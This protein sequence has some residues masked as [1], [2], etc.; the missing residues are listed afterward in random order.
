M[1]SRTGICVPGIRGGSSERLDA[2]SDSILGGDAPI[3]VSAPMGFGK[4][5]F[6]KRFAGR[7]RP[8]LW[9]D[10]S[11]ER[12]SSAQVVEQVVA[13]VDGLPSDPIACGDDDGGTVPPEAGP[14]VVIEDVQCLQDGASPEDLVL[15]ISGRV[16]DPPRIFATTASVHTAGEGDIVSGWVHL[17]HGDLRLAPDETTDFAETI[18]SR[19]ADDPERLFRRTLGIPALV[20]LLVAGKHRGDVFVGRVAAI[21]EDWVRANRSRTDLV[22]TA[23]AGLL[24]RGGRVGRVFEVAGL[25]HRRRSH[26]GAV[27]FFAFDRASDSVTT[28]DLPVP[29]I[30]GAFSTHPRLSP[31]LARAAHLLA[32]QGGLVRAA[33]AMLYGTRPE[34]IRPWIERWGASLLAQGHVLLYQD[35]EERMHERVGMPTPAILEGAAFAGWASEG[36]KRAVDLLEPALHL[37]DPHDAS[38][39]GIQATLLTLAMGRGDE[40]RLLRHLASPPDVTPYAEALWLEDDSELYRE[41]AGIFCG[42]IP[43]DPEVSPVRFRSLAQAGSGIG[44]AP[45][46]RMARFLDGGRSPIGHPSQPRTVHEAVSIA[47]SAIDALVRG[48]TIAAAERHAAADAWLSRPGLESVRAVYAGIGGSVRVLAGDVE[49]LD[50]VR[51]SVDAAISRG[52]TWIAHSWQLVASSVLLEAGAVEEALSRAEQ[53]AD[54][55]G[56]HSWRV[57]AALAGTQVAACLV[58]AGDREAG[59]R[60]IDEVAACID[61]GAPAYLS[62][63]VALVRSAAG[64]A[65]VPLDAASPDTRSLFERCFLRAITSSEDTGSVVQPPSTR[66]PEAH[67]SSCPA[68]SLRVNLFGRFEIV[69]GDR[70]ISDAAW[71][72][73][74]SRLLLAALVIR[75][76]RDIPRDTI[77]QRLWPTM[78]GKQVKDNFYVTWSN[79]RRGL[80]PL[81]EPSRFVSNAGGVCRIDP[82]HVTSDVEEFERITERIAGLDPAEDVRTLL[83]L[84]L[85][86]ARIYSGP[87]L[88][89]ELYDDWFALER[90][91]YHDRFIEAMTLASAAAGDNGDAALSL[92]FA[93]LALESDATREESYLAMMRA[94]R[95]AKQRSSALETFFRCKR[96]LSSELGLDPSQEVMDVY[97]DLLVMESR[98][99]YAP[100]GTLPT[101]EE[102]GLP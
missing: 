100:A 17:H 86:L 78:R 72:K 64:G 36:S 57:P 65:A 22:R 38:A 27:P 13:W 75:R 20:E 48:D 102:T 40:S 82:E 56:I 45:L 3:V 35:L 89:G 23:L 2:I 51:R 5:S 19:G 67:R 4:T 14:L 1:E 47:E 33:E 61:G 8:V 7:H 43:V 66:Y 84:Y 34:D 9:I 29:A 69:S 21:I 39:S 54:H 55:L 59:L 88:A 62:R 42:A 58:A 26:I 101:G 74:K 10:C 81:G 30:V 85:D 90:A 99:A 96:Y 98:P 95:D 97:Q 50:D 87:L 46:S 25:S 6:A 79:L 60:R 44:V 71:A 31:V 18:S 80:A 70:V 76:G 28:L 49:A 24:L 94:Q 63:F 11:T 77:F 16:D 15:G 53:C 37:L 32:A 83:G 93:R 12:P 92:R 41:A 91:S 68:D 73:R 52:E